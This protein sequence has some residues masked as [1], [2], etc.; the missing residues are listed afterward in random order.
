MKAKKSSIPKIIHYCWFGNSPLP[1]MAVKC[2]ESW[3]KNMPDYEIKRWDESNYDVN[4]NQYM[5][6]AYQAK[7]YGF[8]PDYA[9]FDILYKHG[10][11]Y[12]DTDVEIIRSLDDLVERGPFLGLEAGTINGFIKMQKRDIKPNF[13][14]SRVAPGLGIA[15]PAGFPIFKKV[16]DAYESKHFISA[17]GKQNMTNSCQI[18]AQN[19]KFNKVEKID[20]LACCD[21]LYVYPKEYFCPLGYVS[22][23]LKITSN[24]RTIHWYEATWLPKWIRKLNRFLTKPSYRKYEKFIK[25][26][27]AKK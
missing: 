21:G 11:L 1:P 16:L 14:H 17:N 27:D 7:K 5:K 6:E 26:S 25:N 20:D 13:I 23:R 9:R 2:I 19:V 18:F 3:K 22:R 8:V 24:T 12:F 4:K 15:G 10:G